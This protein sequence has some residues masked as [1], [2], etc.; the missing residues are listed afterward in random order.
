M[1]G[2]YFCVVHGAMSARSGSMKNVTREYREIRGQI[3]ELNLPIVGENVD[4]AIMQRIQM[5]SREILQ[6][7]G[8]AQSRQI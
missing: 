6:A 4:I 7:P 5:V 1:K 8:V 2:Q 3:K